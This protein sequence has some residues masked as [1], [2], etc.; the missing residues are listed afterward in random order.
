MGSIYREKE[1]ALEELEAG[2]LAETES[3]EQEL[4][5]QR[6]SATYL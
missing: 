3:I 5:A 4:E 2:R 1:R 6:Q